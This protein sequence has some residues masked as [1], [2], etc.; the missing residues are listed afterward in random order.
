MIVPIIIAEDK[1]RVVPHHK[2]LIVD[3]AISAELTPEEVDWFGMSVVHSRKWLDYLR[4]SPQ[5]PEHE[6]GDPEF[7]GRIREQP[8][9]YAFSFDVDNMSEPFPGPSLIITGRQDAIAGYRDVWNILE[10]YPR[11]TYVVVDRAGHA[12]EEKEDLVNLLINDWLDRV[13]EN[14][15]R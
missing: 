1:K 8:E 2:V 14:T 6:N 12:L 5:I 15:R 9:N 13:E 10:N 7:L 4:T 3:P 11:A